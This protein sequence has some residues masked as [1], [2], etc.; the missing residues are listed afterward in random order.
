MALWQVM[1]AV[2]EVITRDD[3]RSVAEEMAQ[4]TDSLAEEVFEAV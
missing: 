4:R 2:E 3:I 1:E